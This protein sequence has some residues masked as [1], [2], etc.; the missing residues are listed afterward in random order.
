MFRRLTSDERNEVL[1]IDD[2]LFDRSISKKTEML[3]KVFDYCSMKYKKGLRLLTLGWSDGNS[4]VPINHC[5]LS[6]VKDENFFCVSKQYDGRFSCWQTQ[7]T[8]TKK[9]NGCYA[10]TFTRCHKVCSFW[11]L[12]FFIKSNY[13]YSKAVSFWYNNGI[14]SYDRWTVGWFYIQRC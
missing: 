12:I 13:F 7:K 14:L 3:V 5:L 6:A 10:W 11:Q 9:S 1:I 2:S 4:F 8:V